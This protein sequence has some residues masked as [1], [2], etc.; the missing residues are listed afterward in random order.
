MGHL[1]LEHTKLYEEGENANK[2]FRVDED[3]K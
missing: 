3:E 2:Y 1:S